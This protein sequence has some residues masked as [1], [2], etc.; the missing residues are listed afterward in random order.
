[1][2]GSAVIAAEGS[3]RQVRSPDFS[4]APACD[5]DRRRGLFVTSPNPST[6]IDSA[7]HIDAESAYYGS[8]DPFGCR[9]YDDAHPISIGHLHI[10]D[11]T[12]GLSS[13]EL[14]G[15]GRFQAC[16]QGDTVVITR[17]DQGSDVAW[18]HAPTIRALRS[19]GTLPCAAGGHAFT[20]TLKRLPLVWAPTFASADREIAAVSLLGYGCPVYPFPFLPFFLLSSVFSSNRR[21]LRSFDPRYIIGKRGPGFTNTNREAESICVV[22]LAWLGCCVPH[23]ALPEPGSS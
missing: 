5:R 12:H 13:L 2:F 1:M 7:A 4:R 21:P 3:Q 19:A 6:C 20:V 14:V 16:R 10:I 8:R 18:G 23:C 15:V 9:I 17:H 11:K 22:A